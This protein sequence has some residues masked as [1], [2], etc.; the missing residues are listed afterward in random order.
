MTP[1]I[2]MDQ[3]VITSCLSCLDVGITDVHLHYT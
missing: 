1:S 2:V 3:I